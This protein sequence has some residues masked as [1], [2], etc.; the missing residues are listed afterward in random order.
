MKVDRVALFSIMLGLALASQSAGEIVFDSVSSGLSTGGIGCCIA[1]IGQAVTLVAGTERLVNDFK[2]YLGSGNP[3]TFKIQFYKLDGINGIPGTLI[4]ESPTQNYPYTPFTFNRKVIDVQVPLIEVPDTFAWTVTTSD[5]AH[6]LLGSS[7]VPTI[8]TSHQS[9][10]YF[11]TPGEWRAGNS[12]FGAQI[13]VV[14][15]PNNIILVAL[16]IALLGAV[17][18][19]RAPKHCTWNHAVGS[20]N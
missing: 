18:R 19:N 1:P 17:A 16:G 8:G 2:V 4:W 3:Q 13:Q 7:G 11:P 15:E 14:P 10:T 6:G 12:Q 9:W 5:P 20:E